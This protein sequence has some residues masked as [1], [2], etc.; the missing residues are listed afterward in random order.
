MALRR[1]AREAMYFELAFGSATNGTT[2]A[3]VHTDL[4]DGTATEQRRHC[5][6]TATALAEPKHR[7]LTTKSAAAHSQ[8]RE[9]VCRA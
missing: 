7:R 2:G 9:A 4:H 5:H 8:N 1:H 3:L 6:G